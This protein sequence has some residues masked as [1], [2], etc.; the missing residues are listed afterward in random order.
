MLLGTM[1][2]MLLYD[3]FY[4]GIDW[5]DYSMKENV[6]HLLASMHVSI[7]EHDESNS[8]HLNNLTYTKF[9]EK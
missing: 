1:F 5:M 2:S 9:V 8:N 3:F 7:R 4:V 6:A